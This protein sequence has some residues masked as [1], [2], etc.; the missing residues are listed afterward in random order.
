M[1]GLFHVTRLKHLFDFSLSFHTMKST[2]PQRIHKRRSTKTP[3]PHIRLEGTERCGHT[4]NG[5]DCTNAK[6][7]LDWAREGHS[8]RRHEKSKSRHPQCTVDCPRNHK[9]TQ[10]RESTTAT[11][12]TPQDDAM[13]ID[14]ASPSQTQAS[15]AVNQ[16]VS[17]PSNPSNGI[18]TF[19]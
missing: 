3:R 6:G 2:N 4:C 15:T 18:F 7:S 17:G 12:S 8:V 10:I 13:V 5:G 9:I 11:E 14:T 1:F 19:H 16:D